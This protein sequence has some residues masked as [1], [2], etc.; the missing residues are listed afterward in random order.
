MLKY[1]YTT[2][3]AIS[4]Y[5][6]HHPLWSLTYKKFNLGCTPI[7]CIFMDSLYHIPDHIAVSCKQRECEEVTF[8]SIFYYSKCDFWGF[9]TPGQTI[10]AMRRSHFRLCLKM[11]WHFRLNC[12]ALRWRHIKLAIWPFSIWSYSCLK[13]LLKLRC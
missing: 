12:N 3:T 1:G 6:S 9:W 8:F 11:G 5:E 2:L 7:S 10:Q 13:I 4:V